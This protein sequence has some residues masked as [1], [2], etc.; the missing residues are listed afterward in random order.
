VTKSYQVQVGSFN[1]LENAK[2][3]I[4]DIKAAGLPA[5]KIEENGKYI[6]ISSCFKNETKAKER[7]DALKA[8]G[9]N[10]FV[11]RI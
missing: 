3:F 5:R 6:V 1:S 10:A 2:K 11:K 7:V 4:K 9:F 8:A